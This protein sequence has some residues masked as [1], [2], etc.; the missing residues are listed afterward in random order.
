MFFGMGIQGDEPEIGRKT[1]FTFVGIGFL[2]LLFGII[3]S[4]YTL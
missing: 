4:I 3:L 2:V 1:R